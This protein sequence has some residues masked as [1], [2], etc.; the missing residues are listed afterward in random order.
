LFD[1][2]KFTHP[3]FPTIDVSLGGMH[4][5]D[6]GRLVVVAA[7]GRSA[8]PDPDAPIEGFYDNPRWYD[9][10]ADGPV[11]ATVTIQG[12]RFEAEGAW[13]LSAPPD[14][15]AFI[16]TP[17]SLY[18]HLIA[19]HWPPAPGQP[20]N[21]GRPSYT[22]DVYPILAR[23]A[24]LKW[25]R[26]S[27][28]PNDLD[29][30]AAHDA[31]DQTR[32]KIAD[33]TNKLP[34]QLTAVQRDILRMWVAGDYER[35]WA[36]APPP[37]PITPDGLDRAALEGCVGGAFYPG[38][39]AGVW[40]DDRSNFGSRLRIKAE[41]G[42]VTQRMA[43]PWQADFHQCSGDDWWPAQRPNTVI[44]PGHAD[45]LSWDRG[46]TMRSMVDDWAKLGFVVPGDAQQIEVGRAPLPRHDE[47]A[48]LLTARGMNPEEWLPTVERLLKQTHRKPHP[49]RPNT[50]AAEQFFAQ[51][52]KLVE[53]LLA[54]E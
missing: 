35:D 48:H 37:G 8:S 5:D 13:V 32:R 31:D 44:V 18:D 12:R 4:T 50:P 41:P 1:H 24:G 26:D 11:T 19:S 42:D 28:E 22:R 10:V 52:G 46:T 25:V 27:G 39:E 2:G 38:I 29:L 43:L 47:L 15:A 54:G 14:Y 51:A 7:A 34:G 6:E 21:G 16:A 30:P 33:A 45:K 9:D 23:A 53:A 20:G 3:G 17:R 36:G 49:G 40:V